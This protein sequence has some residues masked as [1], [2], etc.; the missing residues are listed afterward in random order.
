MTIYT[1]KTG[2]IETLNAREIAPK[3]AT[4]TMYV[5]DT[6]SSSRGGKAVAVPGELRGLWELHQRYGKL[7]WAQLIEPSIKL[8]REGHIVSPYLEWIFED[9]SDLLSEPT[10]SEIF[11]NPATNQSYKLNDRIKR[12]KLAETLEIIAREGADALYGAGPLRQ[13]FIEEI[14]EKGGIMTEEDLRDYR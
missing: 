6:Q 11:I 7:P 3:L 10:L 14:R 9:A 2:L 13:K 4:S 1:K 12:T 5:N 8:A